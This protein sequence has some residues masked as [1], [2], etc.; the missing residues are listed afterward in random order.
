MA[1]NG[2]DEEKSLPAAH[3]YAWPTMA[4]PA[5]A[6]VLLGSGLWFISGSGNVTTVRITRHS[7]VPQLTRPD[8]YAK[9][10][11]KDES[12]VETDPLKGIPIGNGL[13]LDL[14][15]PVNLADVVQIELMDEGL[16][17][18]SILDRADVSGRTCRGQAFAFEFIGSEST[19]ALIGMVAATIGGIGLVIALLQF[20]RSQVL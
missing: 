20:V 17:K 8:Y 13:N 7:F 6:L 15:S 10:T 11:L 3:P 9:L 14:P 18:D 1:D 12:V 2:S 16:I 4:L 19:Q 5:F